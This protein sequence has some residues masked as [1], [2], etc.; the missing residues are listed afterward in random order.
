MD[1]YYAFTTNLSIT[2]FTAFYNWPTVRKTR[3]SSAR[4]DLISTFAG[5]RYG[6]PPL[7]VTGIP[8]P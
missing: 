6:V 8:L 5:G 1:I 2:M 7:W 3:A 4:G